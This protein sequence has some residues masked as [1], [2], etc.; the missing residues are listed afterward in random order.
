MA[1]GTTGNV[2]SLAPV[3]R[4][5]PA[6]LRHARMLGLATLVAVL[7]ADQLY[8]GYAVAG[9]T[10]SFWGVLSLQV[11]HWYLWLPAG[12]VAWGLG[13]RFPVAGASRRRHLLVLAMSGVGLALGV[14]GIYLAAYHA[15]IRLPGTDALF[16]RLDRSVWGTGAFVFASYFHIELLVF[17][18]IV[19]ARQAVDGRRR[20]QV[21]E[22][23]RLQLEAEVATARL[24]ALSAQMQPHVLFNTLHAV[25][26]LVRQGD[27]PAA[28]RMLADLGQLLRHTLDQGSRDAVLLDEELAYLRS[29]LDIAA[30]RFAGRLEVIWDIEPVAAGLAVPGLL[31]QPLVENA[32]RH[33]VARTSGPCR[34]EVRARIADD[35]LELSIYNDGP[36]LPA[37]WRLDTSRGVGLRS[38]R[39]RLAHAFGGATFELGNEGARGVRARIRIPRPDAEVSRA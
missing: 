16:G 8:L 29:Y 19:A 38:V 7:F 15:V 5:S 12:A 1:S 27:G 17:A 4:F 20:L 34:V 39:S 6:V 35:V 3:G 32:L 2:R 31:L 28:V 26:S 9:V 23:R 33:G 36:T 21:E 24:A 11:I 30:V 18:G 14:L 13:H 10:V 25:A 37:N 22:R